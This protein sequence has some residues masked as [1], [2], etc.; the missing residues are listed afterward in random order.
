MSLVGITA[1]AVRER[2][3]QRREAELT[4]RVGDAELDGVAPEAVRV[5]AFPQ[6]GAGADGELLLGGV[7]DDGAGSGRGADDVGAI[8][9]APAAAADCVD[10]SDRC[11]QDLSFAE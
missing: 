4:D 9:F 7:L 11:E 3:T 8:G 1:A 6:M 10:L 5:A 2:S